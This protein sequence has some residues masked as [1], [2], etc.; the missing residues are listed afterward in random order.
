M[1]RKIIKGR[2]LHFLSE[3]QA[4]GSNYEYFSK[5]YLIISN[6]GKIEEL[7]SSRQNLNPKSSLD[8]KVNR[9]W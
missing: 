5:G 4:N 8:V 9:L 2:L 1:C 3:G 6:E 7:W